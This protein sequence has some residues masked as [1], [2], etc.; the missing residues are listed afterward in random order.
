ML[1]HPVIA[2]SG[3]AG[4]GAVVSGSTPVDDFPAPA[5]VCA[6][7]LQ[8]FG[9]VSDGRRDQ[10]RVH[11]V[12]VV[13]ALCAA[14][15]VAGMA[16]F[17]A[18][19]GWATDVPAEVLVKLYGRRSAPPSKATIWR[20]VT[21]A[22]A[23]AVDAVI[24]AWLLAQAAARDTAARDVVAGEVVVP[25]TDREAPELSAI[26]VDGKAV[27]GATDTEGN[28]VH[29]LAAATHDDALVLGQVEVS[30][31]SNEIP[32]FAPLLDTLA[33]AGVDLA[34]T[35][36][37]AD[38]LHTQ[39]AHADYLH[40]RGAGFVF[41]CKHNQPRLFAALDALPWAQTP[42]AARQVDR[43]H[44]RVTTRTIQVIPAP[45]NLPFPHV[46]QV[47]LIESYV[48]ALD[49]TPTSAV[50]ALG[51]TNLT[52]DTAGPDRLAALVR[53]HW[54]IESLH[55]LRDTV[56]REDNST[57]RTRSGPRVM[58]GLRNL[59][60]GAH[61]LAG[62]RDIAEAS[63]EAGRVMHRPFKILKLT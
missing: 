34:H 18:I 15:V 35:V 51:V 63:R 8:R 22:D 21:G 54:G 60:V 53:N 9:R 56:Y 10:G 13:L 61:H 12:A 5:R 23:A 33:A 58:A 57:V 28:Q 39:R 59:A 46:N 43:G 47:W 44:G 11:P 52:T 50:A 30:A 55:W 19:A 29:L 45:E 38:A 16:S 7:L 24:G 25:E 48:T 62:R 49:G 6:D 20:V 42:I 4:L 26:M 1:L 36:I 32:Q 31:K 40:E 37:T 14:A 17:T 27:R 2:E 41:T 3:F